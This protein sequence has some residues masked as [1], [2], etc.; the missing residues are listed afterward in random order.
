NVER[1]EDSWEPK[2]LR[3]PLILVEERKL[4]PTLSQT[5]VPERKTSE[6]WWIRSNVDLAITKDLDLVS[7]VKKKDDL[8]ILQ[9]LLQPTTH[10]GQRWIILTSFPGWKEYRPNMDYG[11]PYRDAWVHLQAYLVPKSQFRRAITALQG[12]NYFGGWLPGASKW[13][14]AFAGEYPWA[15][16]CNTEPDW[17]LGEL[18]RLGDDSLELIY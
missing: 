14:Y 5:T 12:R 11:T 4:D 2:P 15:T 16:A 1:K 8:P 10:A 13:L 6:C 7:W 9:D 17:Y 18:D 3:T